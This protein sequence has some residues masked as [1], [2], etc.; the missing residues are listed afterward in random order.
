VVNF[1][2]I[3]KIFSITNTKENMFK[4]EGKAG[5]LYQ[6]PV[7]MP[8]QKVRAHLLHLSSVSYLGD[9]KY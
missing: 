9:L 6:C 3:P 7:Y 1:L 5:I 4:K 2:D 8:T